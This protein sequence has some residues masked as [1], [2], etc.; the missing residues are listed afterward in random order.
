MRSFLKLKIL[1][2]KLRIFFNMKT[3][4]YLL[5]TNILSDLIKQPTGRSA[6]KITALGA[7]TKCC[8]SLIVACELRYGAEK[9]G[10]PALTAKVDQLLDTIAVLPLNENILSHYAKIRVTLERA[11]QPIGSN[12][13]LIA[14]HARTEGLKVITANIKEFARVP[15][16]EV[17]N[18]LEKE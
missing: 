18:W 12:D 4:L 16:L 5:D 3:Y 6:Q 14:A 13:L 15:N 11:G 9:K 8:T 17:E 10:S 1:Q 7:E 2:S